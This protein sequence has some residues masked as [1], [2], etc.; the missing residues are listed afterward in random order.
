MELTDILEYDIEEL[1][2]TELKDLQYDTVT[3]LIAIESWFNF[4]LV[5][6]RELCS[7]EKYQE[8]IA[9]L[10]SISTNP[11]DANDPTKAKELITTLS[12]K[13]GI[14]ESKITTSLTNSLAN[15]TKRYVESY[16]KSL[17]QKLESKRQDL[18]SEMYKALNNNDFE[19]YI[20]LVGDLILAEAIEPES[21]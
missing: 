17:E 15:F 1:L 21:K 16:L 2:F 13:L 9:T 12:K 7:P 14:E 19:Q 20:K 5:D 3:N 8:S 10:S 11:Q 18:F 6:L 4:L